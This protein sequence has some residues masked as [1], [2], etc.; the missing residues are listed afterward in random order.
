MRSTANAPAIV[1]LDGAATV[2]STLHAEQLD[3][4]DQRGVRWD[5]PTGPACAITQL[6]RYNERA[7]AADLHGGDAFVPAADH[8]AL[9][10]GKLEWLV[11]VDRA[12]EFLALGA[13]LIEPAGVMHG[14]GLTR[15]RR[16]AGS[17]FG[18]DGL[19]SGCGGDGFC[20]GLSGCGVVGGH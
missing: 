19:Q 14:D 9:A 4:K 10:D 11:A 2:S 8:A 3:V 16:R 5:G 15:A 7:L 6:R 1:G 12:V 17:D 18:V 13:V 20:G